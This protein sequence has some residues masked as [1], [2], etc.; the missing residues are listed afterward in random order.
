MHWNLLQKLNYHV[1][2]KLQKQR[3][4]QQQELQK[5]LILCVNMS[6]QSNM[7]MNLIPIYIL[8]AQTK[9]ANQ[10]I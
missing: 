2:V 9:V 5:T 6:K 8:G 10:K 1:I 3:K 4:I 7:N